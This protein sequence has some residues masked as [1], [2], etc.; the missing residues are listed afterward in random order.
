MGGVWN[1]VLGLLM[2]LIHPRI[3]YANLHEFLK[4]WSW[5]KAHD[6]SSGGTDV[7]SPKR[8]NGFYAAGSFKCSA[9]EALSVSG[10]I[11]LWIQET[12]RPT[13][14]DAER[15]ACDCFIAACDVLDML[16]RTQRHQHNVTPKDLHAAVVLCLTLL[17]LA[18]GDDA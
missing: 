16:K 13:C 10:I 15:S 6:N 17:L 3:T 18:F 1:L 8:A 7:A 11:R 5:P 2:K 9:S 12:V 4:L 14:V